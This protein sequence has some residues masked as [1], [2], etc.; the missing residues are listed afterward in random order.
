MK[1]KHNIMALNNKK[2]SALEVKSMDERHKELVRSDYNKNSAYSEM[3][4]DAISHPDDPTKVLGKGTNSGGHQHYTPDFTK[5]STL[6][7]YSNLDTT[8]GGG[9]YDIHGR[10]EQGGRNRL[11]AI[12]IYNKDNAY[13]PNSVDTTENIEDGQYVMRG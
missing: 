5:P 9:Y 10:N 11:I 7:N 12:N 3:H 13:G 4:E 6:I 2:Q 1:I 8:S